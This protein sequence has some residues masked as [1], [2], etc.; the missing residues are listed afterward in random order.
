MIDAQDLKS[1]LDIGVLVERDLGAPVKRSG[2]WLLFMCPF[3]PNSHTPALGVNP[4]TGSFKCFSCGVQGDVFAWVMKREGVEF[5]EAVQRLAGQAGALRLAAGR[6]VLARQAEEGPPPEEWQVQ[7][8]KYLAFAKYQLLEECGEPGLYELMQRKISVETAVEWGLG[9]NPRALR[10]PGERWGL[11]EEV[12]LPAGLVIP[13]KLHDAIWY[14]KTRV[15]RANR[16]RTP[17]A[18]SE[19]VPSLVPVRKG[20]EMAKYMGVKGGRNALFGGTRMRG[21]GNLLLAE[22]ELDALLA[23]QE[24]GDLVD[25]GTLAGAGMTLG[26]QWLPYLLTYRRVLVAY[27]ADQAGEKGAGKLAALSG[28]MEVCQVP[29]GNDLIEYAQLGGDLR[30]L[31]GSWVG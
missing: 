19:W 8:R 2:A 21:V 25:V 9:F 11:T 3:H 10:M 12:Y 7:A 5:A 26:P 17:A 24:A 27:D 22:G 20:D 18:G 23:W 28:R 6:Q 15:F 1:G 29:V 16:E 14:I 13:C 31:V 30:Q 4:G